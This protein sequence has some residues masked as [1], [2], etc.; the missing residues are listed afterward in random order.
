MKQLEQANAFL[1]RVVV[2]AAIGLMAIA[3]FWLWHDQYLHAV[4]DFAMAIFALWM[5][6]K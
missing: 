2:P 6:N 1:S 4:L 5:R 3:I